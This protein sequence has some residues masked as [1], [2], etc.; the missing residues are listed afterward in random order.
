MPKSKT[1]AAPLLE[2]EHVRELFAIMEANKV[3]TMGDLLT[4]VTQVSAME[5]QLDA[6]VTELAALRR[7]MSAAR[8]QAH[9]V[10]TTVQNAGAALENSVSALRD[11]LGVVRQN[12]IEGCKNAVDAFKEKGISALDNITRFFKVR[13]MLEAMRGDLNK[14]IRAD[15]AAI[16][17][18][19]T[20]GTEYH[21]AGR[22][23]KNVGRA[24]L[25][26]EALPDKKPLGKLSKSLTAPFRAELS[27]LFALKKSVNAALTRL[28]ALEQAAERR[29]SAKKAIAQLSQAQKALPAAEKSLPVKEEAR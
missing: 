10:K 12:V 4:V 17:K 20:A 25:G 8:E 9:P 6:A 24:L 21:E 22:H 1:A 16:A 26:K 18:L 3:L 2:N 14:G 11:K 23:L 13:P 7:E 19:K 28:A 29:P 15:G 5:R 27:C